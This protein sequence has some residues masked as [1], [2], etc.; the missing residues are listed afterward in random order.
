MQRIARERGRERE[1]GDVGQLVAIGFAAEARRPIDVVVAIL[2]CV[3]DSSGRLSIERVELPRAAA[4]SK[5]RTS[6]FTKQT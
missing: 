1:S 5:R 3:T 4:N 2:T 6:R